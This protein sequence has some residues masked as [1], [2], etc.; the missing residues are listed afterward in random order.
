MPLRVINKED[1]PMQKK[2]SKRHRA[3]SA[4]R[5]ASNPPPEPLVGS[6]ITSDDKLIGA[7]KLKKAAAYLRSAPRRLIG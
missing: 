7:L 1:V 5:L 6:I 4:K 2:K 3:S